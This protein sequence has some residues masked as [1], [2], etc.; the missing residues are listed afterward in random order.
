MSSQLQ[1]PK[2]DENVITTGKTAKKQLRLMDVEKLLV[3]G[4]TREKL[5]ER[6][7]SRCQVMRSREDVP[8]EWVGG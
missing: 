3:A 7:T 4:A 5:A 1:L 2:L 8:R 6:V